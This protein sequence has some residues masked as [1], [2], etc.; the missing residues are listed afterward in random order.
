MNRIAR[1]C[2]VR[3]AFGLLMAAS[4]LNG[5]ATTHNTKTTASAQAKRHKPQAIK[6]LTGSYALSDE[7]SMVD[8]AILERGAKARGTEFGY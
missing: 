4:A 3:V 5:C 2:R 1:S 8:S 7:T 6:P